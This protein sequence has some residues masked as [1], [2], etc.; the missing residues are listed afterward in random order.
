MVYVSAPFIAGHV[1]RAVVGALVVAVTTG[2]VG[3][4]AMTGTTSDDALIS[5]RVARSVAVC[6]LSRPATVFVEVRLTLAV[7]AD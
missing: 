3:V 7:V 4:V 1:N 6:V 2:A 5:R